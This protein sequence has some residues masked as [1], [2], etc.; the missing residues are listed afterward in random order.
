[1]AEEAGRPGQAGGEVGE[2]PRRAAPEVAHGVAIAARSIR[3]IRVGSCPA[4]RRPS[5]RARRSA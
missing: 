3:S 5:P 4:R 2:R 1:V